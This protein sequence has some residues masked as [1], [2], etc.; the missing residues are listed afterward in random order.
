MNICFSSYRA[1]YFFDPERARSFGWTDDGVSSL[2]KIPCATRSSPGETLY[3]SW[4][5]TARNGAAKDS[6]QLRPPFL[7]VRSRD[8]E[9]VIAQAWESANRLENNSHYTCL[10][11]LPIWPDIPAGEARSK[12]DLSS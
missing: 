7:L 11:A 5:V 10:Q 6:R 12:T 3:G 1:P 8:G 9:W 4:L 2:L